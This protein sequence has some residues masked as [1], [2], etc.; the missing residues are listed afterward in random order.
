MRRR[1][2]GLAAILLALSA[3]G[4]RQLHAE[5]PRVVASIKPIHSLVAG[6]MRGAGEPALL[7]S[8]AGS[9]HTYSLR[10]SEARALHDA[11]LVFWVGEQLETFL[12][13]PLDT[14]AGQA[15]VIGLAEA[16]GVLWLP[17]REGGSWE[18]HGGDPHGAAENNRAR[19]RGDEHAHGRF[20]MH[21]WLDPRNAAAMVGAIV[22]A[23]DAADPAHAAIYDANGRQLEKRLEQLDREL[24]ARLAVIGERPFLVFHDAYQYLEQRYGLNTVGSI[25]VD[26]QRRPGAQR[27][28]ELR[29]KLEELKVGCVFAEPQFEP[30]LIDTVV[31]GSGASKGVLDPL[32][33][34]LAVGPEHYFELMSGLA[35]G[36]L[37]CLAAR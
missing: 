15:V 2:L 16:P 30:A 33:A 28:G 12:I 19:E 9:P 11:D 35:D 10:P 18:T 36:L 7:V 31:E 4:P 13:K 21:L 14:L 24:E 17:T 1:S 23:L 32:G 5:A 34:E 20:D 22:A 25:T 3:A 26:P 37:D 29:A 6:V 27:L 8:G